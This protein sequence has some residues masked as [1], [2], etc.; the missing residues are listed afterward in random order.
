MGLKSNRNQALIKVIS[1]RV[2]HRE[3]SKHY[4]ITGEQ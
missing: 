4:T 3:Y 2:Q 1:D